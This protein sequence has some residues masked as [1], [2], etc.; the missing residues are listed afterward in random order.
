MGFELVSAL[1]EAGFRI[2]GICVKATLLTPKVDNLIAKIGVMML[3]RTMAPGIIAADGAD[4]D[5]LERQLA[6]ERAKALRRCH[7]KRCSGLGASRL[8]EVTLRN[9][10]TR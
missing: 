9:P 7:G 5:Q 3:P 2:E 6:G 4:P 8:T 10:I 1:R